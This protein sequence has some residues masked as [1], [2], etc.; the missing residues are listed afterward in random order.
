[1]INQPHAASEPSLLAIP[2]LSLREDDV[3][4][5]MVVI[6]ENQSLRYR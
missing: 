3:R 2:S 5:S 6:Q 1:M 4:E